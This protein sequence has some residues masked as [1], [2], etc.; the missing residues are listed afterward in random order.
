MRAAQATRFL[1]ARVA[2]VVSSHIQVKSK[3]GSCLILS[4]TISEADSNNGMLNRDPTNLPSHAMPLRPIAHG[5]IFHQACGG[6]WQ[7][8]SAQ[9]GVDSIQVHG[10]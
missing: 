4:F 8:L 9:V 6:A 5:V 1:N 2:L 7:V 10:Y 3:I